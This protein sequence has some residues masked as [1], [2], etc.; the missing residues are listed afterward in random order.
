MSQKKYT[1]FISYSHQDGDEFALKLKRKITNDPRGKEIIFWQD[2]DNMQYGQWSRQIEEAIDAVEFLIMIITPKALLSSNCKEE[3]IY[4]RLQGV[5]ILPVN[6][7]PDNP[8][9][10]NKFPK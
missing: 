2:Y 5:C 4:A 1:A 9:F 7:L 6:G 3:W 8:A 10:I